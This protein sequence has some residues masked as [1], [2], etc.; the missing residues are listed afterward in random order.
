MHVQ[1]VRPEEL[2][3]TANG[4][5]VPG[6]EGVIY[7]TPRNGSTMSRTYI[8][9][10]ERHVQFGQPE[11]EALVS[12]AG[13]GLIIS[14]HRT[15]PCVWMPKWPEFAGGPVSATGNLLTTAPG[16]FDAVAV[17]AI[18]M[19]SNPLTIDATSVAVTERSDTNASKSV[20][21]INGSNYNVPAAAGTQNGFLPVTWAGS[22]TATIA[23]GSV[24]A[25]TIVVS[26]FTPLSSIPRVDNPSGFPLVIVRQFWLGR[27]LTQFNFANAAE[28]DV[29]SGGMAPYEWIQISQNGVD[30]ATPANAANFTN[31]HT[32]GAQVTAMR[33]FGL[34]FRVRGGSDTILIAGDSVEHGY[35]AANTSTS[36]FGL[37]TV[38]GYI[39]KTMVALANKASPV[40]FINM[41]VAGATS[42][43]TLARAKLAMTAL[44]PNVAWF[45]GYS[46]NDT[47]DTALKITQQMNRVFDF[48]DT[49]R[50]ADIA[51]VLL[52]STPSSQTLALRLDY[53]A[54]VTALASMAESIDINGPIYDATNAAG[55]YFIAAARFDASHPNAAGHSLLTDAVTARWRA[56]TT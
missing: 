34:V 39:H 19:D 50:S 36:G 52:T 47:P 14:R 21:I 9:N 22:A 46:S 7:Q 45:K 37:N 53:N 29:F 41:G 49:A 28:V 26:D 30:G 31:V 12:A 15:R 13:K 8:W 35:S 27:T 33:I 20:P 51:P 5:G 11:V 55:N 3:L 2:R 54:R 23:A 17:V 38:G 24:A 42:A 40:G 56:L 4:P 32:P 16:E 25:P 18:N 6:Q 48:V 44:R 10:G 43:Q 1:I